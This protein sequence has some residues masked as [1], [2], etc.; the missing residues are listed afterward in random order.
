MQFMTNLIF[1]KAKFIFIGLP[2]GSPKAE[3]LLQGLTFFYQ[4]GGEKE[5]MYIL[6]AFSSA[7]FLLSLSLS[8]S[9]FLTHIHTQTHT[10]THELTNATQR[11]KELRI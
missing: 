3:G 10:Y 7:W 8:L 4:K 9:F 11:C 1:Q 2:Q 6:L 5:M